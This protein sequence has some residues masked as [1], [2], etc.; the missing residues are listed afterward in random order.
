[1]PEISFQPQ[2]LMLSL[3]KN[4]SLGP[5]YF[6][7][8]WLRDNCASTIDPGTQ[9]RVYEI[10]NAPEGLCAL[11]AWI[12]DGRLRIVWSGDGHESSYDLDW[13]A[14]WARRPGREDTAQ[15]TRRPWMGDHFDSVRRFSR[16]Q[17]LDQE[18]VLKDWLETMLVE[19][20]AV[21]TDMP[22][23]D[24]GLA[25]LADRVGIV[26][27]CIDGYFLDIR[28]KKDGH[29][30]S[31]TAGAL[32]VHT[33]IPA[34]ELAPGIQ[35]LH[36]RVND[37]TGGES[38]FVDGVA[39]AE[40]LRRDHPDD[41]ALLSQTDIPFFY[42]HDGFD[43]RARQRV[44]E[45]DAEGAVAGITVSGHMQDTLDLDQHA[46]DRFYP[47]L[48]RFH[49]TLN[50][51]KFCMRFRMKAGECLVFDNHRIAHGRTAY[52]PRSGDRH[53]KLCYVDRG[54]MRSTYRT[55][56]RRLLTVEAAE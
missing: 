30:L 11:E 3:P 45:L 24:A 49:Q 1:M 31:F 25:D 16:T 20:I 40:Q 18:S 36:C 51:P 23:N 33:D 50:D 2:G 13:L 19:G 12:E 52:D 15:L 39:V 35:F 47:A 10:R 43:L 46:L 29:S 28:S 44:I 34:E 42:Q 56:V 5:C 38:L 14:Q 21:I 37:A 27:P 26:R 41:F 6:N 8:Y 7:Y 17:V 48:R 53:L 54:E 55:L 22:D 9:E 4:P 32:E